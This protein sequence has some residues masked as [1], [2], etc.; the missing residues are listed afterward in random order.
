MGYRGICR[1]THTC[2]PASIA[3]PFARKGYA[4]SIYYWR[5]T[6]KSYIAASGMSVQERKAMNPANCPAA[7]RR[8]RF[9]VSPASG[10]TTPSWSTRPDSD[11]A[12]PGISSQTPI[13]SR[14]VV[15]A[16]SAV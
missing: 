7:S 8:S 3:L 6:A 1:H 11:G 16:E 15:A 4:S 5:E 9:A 10:N 14:I 13:R 2:N 12:A